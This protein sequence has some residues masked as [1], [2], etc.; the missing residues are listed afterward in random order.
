MRVLVTGA[1]GFIGSTVVDRMIEA[2]HDVVGIDNLSRGTL[3]NLVEARAV[4]AG[5]PGAFAFHS[6]DVTDPGFVDVLVAARPE[7]VCHLAAQVDVRVSVADPVL[8][9]RQNVVGTVTVLEAARRGGVRKVLFASSGGSIYGT[10]TVLPVSERAGV[11]PESPYAAGKAAGELYLRAFAAMYSLQTTA[12]ALSNVYGPRQDPYG[13]AGVVAIF[14]SSLLSGRRATIFG[15]G[16]STRDYVYV[17]DVAAAFVAASGETGNG[18]RF[19]VG[20]AR[21]TAVRDLHTL[22]AAAV[23][24]PDEPLFAPPRTGELQAIALD[25]AAARRA[26]RWEAE[27]ALPAGLARTVEWIRQQ[28]RVG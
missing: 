25:S 26:L 11:S 9:A 8:D 16:D 24:A 23:G 13:E 14:A 3:G 18:R 20:S 15:D 22:I 17:D 10:P 7:V 2:G 1:A 19:N 28:L 12:L 21:Q 4:N 27:V 6:A 5:R